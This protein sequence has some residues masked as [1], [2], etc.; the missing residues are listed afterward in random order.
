MLCKI[1]FATTLQGSC[2]RDC[3]HEEMRVAQS[4]HHGESQCRKT[5]TREGRSSSRHRVFACVSEEKLTHFTRKGDQI[6]RYNWDHLEWD[7]S[8]VWNGKTSCP[9]FISTVNITRKPSVWVSRLLHPPKF[10]PFCKLGGIFTTSVLPS[11]LCAYSFC[12]NFSKFTI[13]WWLQFSMHFL[14][15]FR[16]GFI[17]R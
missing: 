9:D 11:Q 10:Q 15:I 2:A 1:I 14:L 3:G 16:K 5:A 17:V 7:H 8:L 13:S 12:I 6:V 4:L